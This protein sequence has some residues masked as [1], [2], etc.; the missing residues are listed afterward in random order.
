MEPL[1]DE[2]LVRLETGYAWPKRDE[3]TK[4]AAREIRKLRALVAASEQRAEALEFSIREFGK[5]VIIPAEQ[6][7]P[8]EFSKK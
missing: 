5:R 8:M 1:T 4:Q 3:V 2:D 7:E 6:P